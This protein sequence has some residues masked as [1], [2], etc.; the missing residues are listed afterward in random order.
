MNS[1]NLYVKING[2]WMFQFRIF[3]HDHTEAFRKAMHSLKAEH[4]SLPI[5]L[6]QEEG[7]QSPANKME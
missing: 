7:P 2:V 1:Y 5:R 6:E 4:Y 3:A